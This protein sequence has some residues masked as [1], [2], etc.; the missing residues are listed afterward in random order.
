MTLSSSPKTCL[1]P[2]L[3]SSLPAL[4]VLCA[5]MSAAERV[6]CVHFHF[7]HI[8]VTSLWAARQVFFMKAITCHTIKGQI[9]LTISSEIPKRYHLLIWNETSCHAARERRPSSVGDWAHVRSVPA[10]LGRNNG[11]FFLSL[12]LEMRMI[13]RWQQLERS[14]PVIRGLKQTSRVNNTVSSS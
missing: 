11:A 12:Y 1:S 10:Y 4:D 8:K 13:I 7:C 2:S 14:K 5:F 9:S 3:D 6:H